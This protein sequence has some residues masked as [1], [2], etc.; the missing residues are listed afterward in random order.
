MTSRLP[1]ELGVA[2]SEG[3]ATL[4]GY[5][6]LGY[7]DPARFLELVDAAVAA[8]LDALELGLPVDDPAT[9]AG[10]GP[11]I[12]EALQVASSH[13]DLDESLSL[14][15]EVR[16]RVEV[17]LV[18][19]AYQRLVSAIGAD[20]LVDRSRK[21]GADAIL[22]PDLL[23]AEQLELARTAA[24]RDLD[25]IVF[26]PTPEEGQEVAK[27]ADPRLVAYLASSE[28]TTGGQVDPEVVEARVATFR[29]HAPSVPLV[30][31]FGVWGAADAR[32]LAAAGADGVAIGTALVQAAAEG[33][34]PLTE[35]VRAASS[36]LRNPEAANEH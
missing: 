24:D 13:C 9:L 26:V 17:P 31:G 16:D 22:V 12:R 8:G 35:F 19:L 5:V 10:E 20:A 6:P 14:V 25:T 18:A 23:F 27:R 29:R 28:G 11:V 21:A 30:V 15:A 4:V 7:P 36:A 32:T 3:R 2:R 34:G 33:T 1:A